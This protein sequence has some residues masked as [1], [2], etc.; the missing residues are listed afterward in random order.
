MSV[1]S[2]IELYMAQANLELMIFQAL[3][4][5]LQKW[6][7]TQLQSPLLAGRGGQAFSPSTWEA[8]A[9]RSLSSSLVSSKAEG[10]T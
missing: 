8:E 7:T 2:P 10:A 6:T 4:L 3:P 1:S 9:G 5:Q